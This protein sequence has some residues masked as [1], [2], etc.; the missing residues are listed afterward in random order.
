ML[1]HDK[2]FVVSVDDCLSLSCVI[3]LHGR[4]SI[5]DLRSCVQNK[6]RYTTLDV[7]YFHVYLF[8]KVVFNKQHQLNLVIEL[9]T[10]VG[11]L[12]ISFKRCSA[13]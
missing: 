6:Q 10:K 4:V 12:N 5:I 11:S 8:T 3:V 2:T 1:R 9:F 7:D 13:K